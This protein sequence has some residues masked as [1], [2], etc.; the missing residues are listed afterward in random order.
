MSYDGLAVWVGFEFCVVC[1]ILQYF[2]VS[3]KLAYYRI[4][5][6][7]QIELWG[8]LFSVWIH[9]HYTHTT[10]MSWCYTYNVF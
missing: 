7:C 9:A 4:A 6:L 2:L 3:Y 8:Y 5:T 10:L 1:Q